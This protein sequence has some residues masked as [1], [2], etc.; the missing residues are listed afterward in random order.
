[1][2][3]LAKTGLALV[4]LWLCYRHWKG[5]RANPALLKGAGDGMRT[6]GILALLLIGF[7]GCIVMLLQ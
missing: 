4:L 2:E 3:A 5:L 7:V 6:M 1:M